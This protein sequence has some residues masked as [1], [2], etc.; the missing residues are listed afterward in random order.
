M[1][2]FIK[3]YF[4][5][6]NFV[7]YIYIYAFPSEKSYPVKILFCKKNSFCKN[8]FFLL[9]YLICKKHFIL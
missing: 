5:L 4:S 6:K 3:L 8:D 2:N 7:L 9:K 1:H